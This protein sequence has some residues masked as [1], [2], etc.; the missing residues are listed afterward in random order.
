MKKEEWRPVVGYEGL[1]MVSN[2]GRVKSLNYRRTGKEQ[3]I[4]SSLTV[5]K[6]YKSVQLCKNGHHST[7]YVHILVTRAFPE[8]CGEWFPGAVCNH[9]DENGLNNCAWNLEVSTYSYNLRYGTRGER[10]GKKISFAN[11]NGKNSKCVVQ[12][13]LDGNFVRSWPSIAQVERDTGF[14]NKNISACCLGKR[15]TAYGYVWKH[16]KPVE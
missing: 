10:A 7:I 4:H 11:T 1:Y 8:I 13:D 12:Y 15:K 16:Y 2:F 9:K 5:G 3:I 6:K 14:S